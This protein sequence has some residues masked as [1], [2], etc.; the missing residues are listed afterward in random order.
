MKNTLLPLLLFLLLGIK[1]SLATTIVPYLHLGELAQNSDAVLVVKAKEQLTSGYG[2]MVFADFKFEVERAVKG[3]FSPGNVV[4]V[5]PYSYRA[6]EIEVHIHGDFQPQADKTYLL[7]LNRMNDHWKVGTLAFYVLEEKRLGDDVYWAPVDEALTVRQALRPDGQTAESLGVYRRAELLSAL[8]SYLQKPEAGWDISAART[9]FSP[10]DF[11]EERALPAGCDFSFGTDIGRWF[12]DAVNIYYD[13]VDAPS[14][15]ASIVS[16]AVTTLGD[17]YTG[18]APAYSGILNYT[19]TCAGSVANNDA[20]RIHLL[21]INSGQST[22][23]MFNDPCNQIANVTVNPSGSCVGTLAIG[24]SWAY[25]PKAVYDGQQWLRAGQG[26]VVVNENVTTCTNV[27]NNRLLVHE[28]THVYS[29]GHL[30]AASYPNQNMNPI[31][32]NAVGSKDIECMDHVYLAPLPVEL[33]RYDAEKWRG[34]QA[35]LTWTTASEKNNDYFFLERSA[36]G[37]RFERIARVKGQNTADGARYEWIDERPFPGQNYYRLSQVDF[38]G[39]EHNHGIRAVRIGDAHGGVEVYPNPLTADVLKLITAFETEYDGQVEIAD[40]AGRVLER[41]AVR[42]D[43]GNQVS[44]ISVSGLPS[45][46]YWLR[47]NNGLNTAVQKF[48]KP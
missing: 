34:R 12:N 17:S 20:L 28:L 10:R 5:R 13:P 32:C 29:M 9:A 45:G 25:S 47:L 30:N 42:L 43:K 1:T 36:D 3:A 39:K 33:T 38:D 19:N 44:E 24:G 15:A 8:R 16:G 11:V 35:R 7:F 31:C 21:T 40:A 23:V 41:R 37:L 22:L 6:S 48:I 26:F 4:V 14:D 2:A 18:I 46:V 27:N